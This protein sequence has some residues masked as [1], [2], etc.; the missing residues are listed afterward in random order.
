MYQ[1]E[2][3]HRSEISD[4]LHGLGLWYDADHL[5]LEGVYLDEIT[6]YRARRRWIK[7]F[8]TNFLLESEHDFRIKVVYE[9][10]NEKFCVRCSFLTACGRYAFWRLTHHQAPEVQF[11]LETAHLPCMSVR[12]TDAEAFLSDDMKDMRSLIFQ[13]AYRSPEQ[14]TVRA[15]GVVDTAYTYLKS[16]LNRVCRH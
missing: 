5:M 12:P 3:E 7:T 10:G 2:L 1:P 11:L 14:P 15:V 16:L 4:A 13:S 8:E 9:D 6:A